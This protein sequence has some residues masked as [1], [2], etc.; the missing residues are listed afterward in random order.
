MVVL[1]ADSP[2]RTRSRSAA[3]SGIREADFE[4]VGILEP[5]LTL[6]DSQAF[7]PLTVAQALY[8]K[9]LPADIAEKPRRRRRRSPTSSSTRSPVPTSAALRRSSKRRCRT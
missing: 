4:V 5:T 6:P 7:M 9:D 3:R 8:L 2:A 1:G